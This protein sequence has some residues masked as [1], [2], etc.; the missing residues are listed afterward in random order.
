[1]SLNDDK[2]LIERLYAEGMNRRDPEGP[3]WVQR[4]RSSS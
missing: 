2:A 4:A 1:M 3:C